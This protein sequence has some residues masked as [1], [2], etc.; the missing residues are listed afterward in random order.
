MEAWGKS[1]RCGRW[2]LWAEGVKVAVMQSVVVSLAEFLAGGSSRAG[3]SGE[4]RAESYR[5]VPEISLLVAG[6]GNEAAAFRRCL[7][8]GKEV[9]L[10]R[11]GLQRRDA[12]ATMGPLR[13]RGRS[14]LI[15]ADQG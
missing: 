9:R 13:A 14:R 6:G 2:R 12:A 15:K 4:D 8:F 10:R 5:I 3:Q 7:A 1:G 11:R